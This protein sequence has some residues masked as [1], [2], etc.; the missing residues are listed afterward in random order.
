MIVKPRGIVLGAYHQVDQFMFS[1]EDVMANRFDRP[2]G[3]NYTERRHLVD[4]AIRRSIL[5]FDH[6]E[7]PKTPQSRPI[8]P[9]SEWGVLVDQG[10]LQRTDVFVPKAGP[11]G[12]GDMIG[13]AHRYVFEQL[14]ARQPGVWAYAP[15]LLRPDWGAQLFPEQAALVERRGIGFELYKALPVPAPDVPYADILDFKARYPDELLAMRAYLDALYAEIV[16]SGDLPMAKIVALQRLDKAINDVMAAMHGSRL[17]AMFR[18]L[19]VDV[20]V[21]VVSDFSLGD[22]IAG[23][24]HS[25]HPAAIGGTIAL[26]RFVRKHLLSPVSRSGPLAYIGHADRERIINGDGVRRAV[27]DALKTSR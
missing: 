14:E 27:A 9:G 12:S 21:D 26:Y 13:G 6:I 20:L 10:Y 17:R 2:E 5:Y 19:N 18:S 15:L 22:W 23:Y 1:I 8:D 25:E 16:R 11:V 4:P 3:A 24:V 7:F